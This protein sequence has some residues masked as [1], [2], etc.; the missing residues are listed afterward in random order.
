[1]KKL[2]VLVLAF[3]MTVSLF[4]GCSTKKAET[5][6]DKTVIKFWC[7]SNEPWVKAYSE[8]IEKFEAENPEYKVE[9]T[10]YPYDVYSEKIQTALTAD[11]NSVDVIA[12]WGGRAPEFIKTDALAEVPADLEKDLRADYLEPAIGIYEKDSKLYGVAM[13]YNLEYGGM[14][15]NKKLFDEAGLSYPTTWEE[16]RKTSKEVAKSEGDLMTMRGFDM[17]D[18]DALICNYLAMILQQGGQYLNADNSIDFATPEGIKAMEEAMSMVTNKEAD[19]EGIINHEYAFNNMYKD[20]GF[21]ASVGSWGIGEGTTAYDLTLGTDFDY[22]KVPQYGEKMGFAAETGWGLVVPQNSKKQ[23]AAWKF[24]EFFVKPENLVQHNIACNQLP[25]RAS[26]LE[27]EEY[28][29][30]MPQ[31]SF[32]LDIMPEGQWMGAYN[33]SAMREIFNAKFVELCQ[34]EKPDVKTALQ[35][36]SKQITDECQITYTTK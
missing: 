2:I 9:L 7:H 36:I 28:L 3:I 6:E 4:T 16:L 8:M 23:D 24:I 34:A 20:K 31:V 12:V 17:M 15:T 18:G 33:T 1:M 25:P 32:L 13:E 35:E 19:L 14:L 26:L 22:V 11:K 21:M 30:A 27:N 10:D 29:K 5:S